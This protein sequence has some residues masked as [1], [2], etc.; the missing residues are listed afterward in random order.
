MAKAT[1]SYL[2]A[3]TVLICPYLCLG[4]DTE[5]ADACA[6]AVACTCSDEPLGQHN[7]APESPEGGDQDCLCR[8]AIEAAKIEGSD[9]GTDKL[10]LRWLSPLELGLSFPSSDC[11]TLK[12]GHSVH[13][14]TLSSG[15]EICAQ[16]NSR[17]L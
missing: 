11:S 10:L 6:Q 7:E 4:E 8:G 2:L 17:L 13:F 1:L 16:V 5:A 15:R 14:P 9:Y 12:S 3:A